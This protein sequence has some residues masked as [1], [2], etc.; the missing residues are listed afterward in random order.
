MK[1]ACLALDVG[2]TKIAAALIDDAGTVLASTRRPTPAIEGG[3]AV[4]AQMAACLDELAATAAQHRLLGIGIS[5]AGVI[6]PERAIVLDSTDAIRGWKGQDFAAYFG[7]RYALPVRADNDVHCALL[8]ELWRNPALAG[9]N[10]TVAMLTLGTGL[11]GA[12]A[13]KGRLLQGRHNLAGHFGRT[14]VWTPEA[15][16]LP[17]ETMVSGSGLLYLYRRRHGEEA[18]DGATVMALAHAG[19][20]VAVAALDAWIGHLAVQLHNLHWSIDPDVVLLGGGVV[21]SRALWWDALQQRIAALD[22]PIT[23]A[24]ATLGNRAGLVGAAKLVWNESAA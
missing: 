15:G 21:D 13:H 4:L 7:A 6:D 20:A 19:D 18:Y 11:G 16:F 14:L 24:P 23:I 17:V 2:G 9:V 12:L 5:A 10:G 22:A 1:R 3:A 8:G